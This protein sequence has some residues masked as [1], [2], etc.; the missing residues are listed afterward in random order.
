MI[1]FLCN[2]VRFYFDDI[3][4]IV[5]NYTGSLFLKI[6]SI[7]SFIMACNREGGAFYIMDNE[8]TPISKTNKYFDGGNYANN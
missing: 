4:Q 7:N 6:D 5:Y 1:E 8:Y 2:D 3:N